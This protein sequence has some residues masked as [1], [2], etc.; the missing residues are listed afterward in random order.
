L[1][2]VEKHRICL[3]QR[4]ICYQGSKVSHRTQRPQDNLDLVMN[5]KKRVR[6]IRNILSL[7][8]LHWDSLSQGIVSYYHSESM[9]SHM[10]CYNLI[11]LRLERKSRGLWRIF[12]NQVYV[13]FLDV[14]FSRPIVSWIKWP[15]WQDRGYV[16]I[17]QN[18]LSFVMV[19]M[20]IV[21]VWMSKL[22]RRNQQWTSD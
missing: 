10:P 2:Q 4:K 21:T 17:Q 9:S 7:W 12:N 18:G 5:W 19:S 3:N 1:L 22:M 15:Y 16:P 13:M 11:R 20:G 6:S 14:S 8:T